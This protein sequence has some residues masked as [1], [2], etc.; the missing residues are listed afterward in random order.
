MAASGERQGAHDLAAQDLGSGLR[1]VIVFNVAVTD[2]TAEAAAIQLAMYRAMSPSARVQ[3][4]VD[5]SDAVRET[6]RAGIRRR[7]PEYSEAEVARAF[8]AMLY[9]K[10][11]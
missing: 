11:R 1:R 8:I 2:T 3:I 4:A 9:G 6:A 5:L 10:N 7:H